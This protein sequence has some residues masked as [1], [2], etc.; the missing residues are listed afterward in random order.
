M[1]RSRRRAIGTLKTKAMIMAQQ[2]ETEQKI[3][4]VKAR[5]GVISTRVLTVLLAS[6]AAVFVVWFVVEAVYRADAPEQP[7]VESTQPGDVP[8]VTPPASSQ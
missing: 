4:P 5:Q 6:L 2:N 1:A 8:P 3:P 7:A